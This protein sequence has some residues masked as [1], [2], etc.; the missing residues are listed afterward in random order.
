V[1][2]EFAGKRSIR[3][4]DDCFAFRA[5]EHAERHIDRGGRFL[6]KYLRMHHFERHRLAREMEMLETALGLRA[7][8]A[9]GRHFNCAHCVVFSAYVGHITSQTRVIQTCAAGT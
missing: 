1:I 9:I 8:H 2:I 3:G 4:S 7:P 5:V 6:D